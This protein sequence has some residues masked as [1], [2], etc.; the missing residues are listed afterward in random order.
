MTG[1]GEREREQTRTE[2]KRER[3][4][5]GE[6]EREREREKY[7]SDWR[8]RVTYWAKPESGLTPGQ[9]CLYVAN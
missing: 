3:G 2:S 7:L 6:R 1:E 5:G 4:G 9:G 8:G